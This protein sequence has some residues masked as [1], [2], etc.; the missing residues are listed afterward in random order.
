LIGRQN[1]L[2]VCGT[3]DHGSTSASGRASRRTSVR[4]FIDDVHAQQQRSLGATRWPRRPTAARRVPTASLACSTR[5]L[6]GAQVADLEFDAIYPQWVR[7][8]SE[9]TLDAARRLHPRRELLVTDERSTVLD[10]GSGAGKFCLIGA[11]STGAT[12]VGVEQRPRLVRI[13]RETS[14]RAGVTNVEFIHDNAMSLDWGS[15]TLSTSTIRF[16]STTP[17]SCRASTNRSSCRRSCST[18]TFS[19][20]A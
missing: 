12:F 15:S 1:V 17:A 13:A 10:V 14:R 16:T 4:E 2:F 6:S 11:A 19:P 9:A 7:R 8:L 5:L 20:R 18:T 3:D